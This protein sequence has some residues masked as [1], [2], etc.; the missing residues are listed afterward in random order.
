MSTTLKFSPGLAFALAGAPTKLDW[1][2]IINTTLGN[3]RRVRGFR[4][5]SSNAVD[6]SITGAEFLNIGATGALT[7]VSGNIVGLGM[8]SGTT[9][10]NPVDLSTGTAVLRIEGNGEWV[11]GTLGLAN[12]GK[13]FVISTNLLQVNNLGFSFD[14]QAGVRAPA[15]LDS[16]TGYLAPPIP[17]YTAEVEDWTGGAFQRVVG[18]LTPSQRLINWVYDDQEMADSQGDVLTMIAPT[19]VVHGE[20]EFG[21]MLWGLNGAT[22]SE[23]SDPVDEIL[24][25]AK[26]TAQ[27]WPGYPRYSGYDPAVS[28]TYAPPYKVRIKRDGQTIKV[29]E[30]RDGLAINDQTL[31]QWS[32]SRSQQ[33]NID[34]GKTYFRE[35]ADAPIRPFV[36]CAVVLPFR[37]HR[38]KMHTYAK[39][40]Y[41]GQELEVLRSSTAKQ[42]SSIGAPY[43]ALYAANTNGVNN[44]HGM[45]KWA[46]PATEAAFQ[47]NPSLDPMLY[48]IYSGEP[49][50]GTM[51]S[52]VTNV[53]GWGYEPGA[54]GG[55][56]WWTGNGGARIDRGVIPGPIA[57]HQ[58]DPTYI[59]KRDNTP[60][61]EM[62]DNWNL[63]YCNIPWHMI[64]DVTTGDTI[65]YDEVCKGL[66]SQGGRTY[67]GGQDTYVQGGRAYSINFLGWSA[68]PTY[69]YTKPFD[70]A[71]VDKNLLMPFQGASTDQ[72]H[73]YKSAA[74]L[75]YLYNSPMA[76]Y[77]TK[78][79]V[80]NV[81][82]GQLADADPARDP[83]GWFLVR[84]HAWRFKAY[85]EAW[86]LSSDHPWGMKRGVT[87]QRW[88]TELE[89]IYDT[90]YTRAVLQNS[91]DL[92]SLSLVRLGLPLAVG[93]GSYTASATQS[94]MF[95]MAGVF[96]QMK[97]TGSW[98]Y[99][100]AVSTKCRV[101]LDFMV[102][103][104]DRYS[105]D[106]I[107][108]T[109]G[110]YEWYEYSMVRTDSN[111]L[112]ADWAEVA[113]N[114]RARLPANSENYGLD[115]VTNLDGSPR[116][117][118][119][120]AQHLRYQ[121]ACIRRDWITEAEVPRGSTHTIADGIAKYKGFYDVVTA[122]VNA[123]IAAD[124]ANTFNIRAVD[125]GFR[126]PMYG[127]ILPPQNI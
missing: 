54:N 109:N 44:W 2:Q 12:S 51:P 71:A 95:Y 66:W 60:I 67:Y 63:N 126:Q 70:G 103:C 46:T 84:Q 108:E 38:L 58:T 69:D 24:I 7:V 98:D 127:V 74:L 59:H 125:W 123:A 117:E 3:P 1:S 48:Q 9:V 14:P 101:A 22:N 10:K 115:W 65:P 91:Q 35:L 27:N 89:T 119:D 79:S 68:S 104:M 96:Q 114:R 99:M 113:A 26:P 94:L 64:Q 45:C 29:H 56:D 18:I 97:A 21:M 77:L 83:S 86:K 102:Q 76:A 80:I 111:G 34:F 110:Q 5:P 90:I 122:R 47:A 118:Q 36:G 73:P 37:S 116:G 87:V 41:P 85:M 31:N 93:E 32:H 28:N 13:D 11:Q 53:T 17:K 23:G 4:D 52:G 124:P 33:G 39:K 61:Q 20:I 107:I 16:G 100:R 121:W 62:V 57:A 8:L 50:Y 30:M 49:G 55:H 72:L 75:A 15:L 92:Y 6:P 112:V 40:Y 106:W 105:I 43:V 81:I 19:T 120:G 25:T 42:K 82:L 88:K 78:F